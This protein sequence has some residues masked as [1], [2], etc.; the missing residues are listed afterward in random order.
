LI[1]IVLPGGTVVRVDAHVDV[2][3]LRRI[4]GVLDGR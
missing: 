3:A 2:R 1:E 4:L